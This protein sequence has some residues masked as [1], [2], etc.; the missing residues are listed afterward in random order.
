[1]VGLALVKVKKFDR[2]HAAGK[3]RDRYGSRIEGNKRS[4][5]NRT[6]TDFRF[7]RLQGEFARREA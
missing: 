4:V 3:A 2:P 1:M 6:A 5:N 7:K